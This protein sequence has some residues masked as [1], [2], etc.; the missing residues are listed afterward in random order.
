MARQRLRRSGC[1][2][3]RTNRWWGFGL[4]LG[5]WFLF[6]AHVQAQERAD[7]PRVVLPPDSI[8]A[9]TLARPTPTV[10]TSIIP[11]GPSKLSQPVQFT[12]RDS[13]IITFKDGKSDLGRLIGETLVGYGDANMGAHE[14]DILFDIT[15]LRAKGLPVDTGMVGRPSFA[16]GSNQFQGDR[17]AY[18]L[19]TERGRVVGARTAYDDGFI[20]AGIAK[21]S[22]DS[23]L[24]IRNGIYTTCDCPDDPSYSL[25]SPKMKI[26][27]QKWIYTGP[28]QL[29]IFN[30]PTPLWLPFGMLPQTESRRS[31]PLE[32]RYGED[33][34]GFYLQDWGWYFAMNDYT[35]L[36][37]Q[38]GIWTSGS[39]EARS[40]FRYNRRNAYTGSLY[41][42]TGRQR[43]GERGDP[44]F[45]VRASNSI[46]WTHSQ[47]IDPWTRLSGNV[48][49]SSSGAL[50]STTASYNDQVTQSIQSTIRISRSWQNQGRSL[51]VSTNQRQ[52]LSSGSATLTLPNMSFSQSSRKP[53]QRKTRQPGQQEQ[54]F[55][56][57]TYSYS[58]NLNNQYNFS[59]LSEEQLLAQ[60]DTAAA[61][62]TWLDA[63]FSQSDYER[64]TGNDEPFNF[65]S[66]H[67]IP[68]QATFAISRLPLLGPFRWNVSP[69][70]NY[71][72]DWFIR[73]DRQ[74]LQDST[75]T[76]DRFT[77]PGFF[78]LRQ[79]SL[80]VTTNTTF[81]GLFPFRVSRYQGLRH[82]VQ[83]SLAFTF[84]PDF[85]ADH[86]GYTRSY[87]NQNGTEVQYP[88]VSGVSNGLQ[89]N[90]AFN[91]RN[92][93]ETKDVQVDSTG[94]ESSRTVRLFNVDLSTSYNF[95]ADSLR[96]QN[97]SLTSRTRLFGEVD[98]NFRSTFSPYRL[99][100]NS[101]APQVIDAYVF[102]LRSF[103]FAR[104]TQLNV[105]ARTS[106][107]SKQ[108]QGESRVYEGRSRRQAGLIGNT[109]LDP[110][111]P[112]NA[113]NP[114]ATDY[115]DFSGTYADFA[116][117]WSLNLD[118]TYNISKLTTTLN[119]RAIIN[120][121]FD[122]NLTPNWKVQGRSGYD[123][124]RKE[125][126]TTNVSLL[127]DLECWQMSF[128]WTPFGR[129]RSYSFEL[130]VKSGQLRD[131]L[132]FRR[133]RSDAPTQFGSLSNI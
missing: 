15:E 95:A 65:R 63:L 59:P 43:N 85:Y 73:T 34:R 35:D 19:E 22:E 117:P 125:M 39:W 120:G 116:I 133:P 55:E 108:R 100:A 11:P 1:V 72:E 71:T 25:R 14:I 104:L 42:Q 33:N 110:Q 68:I 121:S 94:E 103:K 84:R 69:N 66:T 28:L 45:A 123:I 75:S 98:I 90:L 49:L 26:V 131:L 91:L 37:L 47:T 81:Y 93:F 124:E 61:N 76:I 119:R 112:L 88:L 4:L 77:V 60:G 106:I 62:I 20:R 126:A 115:Q 118:F 79:F 80:G 111:S 9:D 8:Q 46:R 109:N 57:I 48:N 44:D 50:R 41:L 129:F 87:V 70:I 67:R 58:F 82:T 113:L 107:R 102:N 132:R 56:K 10:P 23:T 105:T 52:V 101:T 78:A 89:Q 24:Y 27:D 13:L 64:A 12:A 74:Q 128:S 17:V 83:P 96:L 54:W 122:F 51:D 53:F 32:V 6:G 36:M 2:F 127:R 99:S 114:Y 31:G 30:I 5:S 16:Q 29:Y 130:S 3:F 97:I 7:T 18:N 86:W 92:V 40:Q 38:G 21:I